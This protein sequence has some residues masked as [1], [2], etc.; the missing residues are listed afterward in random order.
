MMAASIQNC[1]SIQFEHQFPNILRIRSTTAVREVSKPADYAA[2]HNLS[3]HSDQ[4]YQDL[5]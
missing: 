2:Q 5:C 3:K 4:H 1:Y